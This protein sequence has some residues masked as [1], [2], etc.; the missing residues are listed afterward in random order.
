[1]TYEHADGYPSHVF[2]FIPLPFPFSF[3]SGLAFAQLLHSNQ[4]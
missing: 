4:K 1:M 3:N 2:H